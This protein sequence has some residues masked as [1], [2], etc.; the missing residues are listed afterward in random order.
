VTQEVIRVSAAS[1]SHVR[2]GVTLKEYDFAPGKERSLKIIRAHGAKQRDQ[3][4]SKGR[5]LHARQGGIF[6]PIIPAQVARKKDK[7]IDS[8]RACLNKKANIS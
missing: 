4:D 8:W 5:Q 2:D 6:G 1:T 3:D 7:R